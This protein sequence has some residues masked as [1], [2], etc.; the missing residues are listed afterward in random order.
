MADDGTLAR[1]EGVKQQERKEEKVVA[2]EIG[3][4]G[5][6]FGANVGSVVQREGIRPA[7]ASHE[8]RY[9]ERLRRDAT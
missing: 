2:E 6:D 8:E 9:F 7:T 1:E 4:E 5:S 3:G